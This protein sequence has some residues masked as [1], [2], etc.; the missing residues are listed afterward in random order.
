MTRTYQKGRYNKYLW[1]NRKG[2]ARRGCPTGHCYCRYDF[3][4][5]ARLRKENNSYMKFHILPFVE[6]ELKFKYSK[7]RL[8]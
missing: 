5:K 3:G 2:Y 8:I 6:Q 1:K 4:R 7:T